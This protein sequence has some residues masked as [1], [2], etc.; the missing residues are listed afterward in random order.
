MTDPMAVLIF[1]AVIIVAEV[2]VM[3]F[4]KRGWG[5]HSVR[6]V[7]LSMIIIATIFLAVSTVGPERLSAAYAVLGVAAG[8]LVGRSENASKSAAPTSSED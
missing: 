3:I 1:G 5:N 4:R 6:V 2:A 7:G 8:Y